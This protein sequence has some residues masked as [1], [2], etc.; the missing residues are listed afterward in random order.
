MF[1]LERSEPVK[2][3]PKLPVEL[4][5]QF[6]LRGCEIALLG[7]AHNRNRANESSVF[8]EKENDAV[9]AVIR[10]QITAVKDRFG[11]SASI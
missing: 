11:Q 1:P 5:E 3:G 10:R 7:R 6:Y 4:P 8:P 2:S 9:A